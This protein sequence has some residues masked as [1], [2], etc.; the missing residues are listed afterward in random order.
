MALF[1]LF[2][3][4]HLEVTLRPPMSRARN[5]GDLCYDPAR[6]EGLEPLLNAMRPRDL[7]DLRWTDWMSP[8]PNPDAYLALRELLVRRC[9]EF[10]E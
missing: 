1:E 5:A 10:C 3:L 8:A 6:L 2:A 9:S 4:Y 7:A